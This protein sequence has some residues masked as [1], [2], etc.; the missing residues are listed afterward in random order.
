MNSSLMYSFDK[1]FETVREN[2][3]KNDTTGTIGGFWTVDIWTMN[4]IVVRL[5]DEGYTRA[6]R[7]PLIHVVDSGGNI[8]WYRGDEEYLEN[9]VKELEL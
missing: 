5:E 7:T 9:L 2:G 8:T 6:I 3:S 4:D 1:V